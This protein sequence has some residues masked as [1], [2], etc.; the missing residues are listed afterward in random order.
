MGVGLP[1]I[2]LIGEDL[3][4]AEWV[5]IT[6]KEFGLGAYRSQTLRIITKMPNPALAHAWYYALLR[7][8][9][10]YVD[11][12]NA[13]TKN[14]YICVAN[15]QVQAKPEAQAW[16]IQLEHQGGSQYSIKSTFL[17]AGGMHFRPS[18]MA[19]LR[20][21]D[22]KYVRSLLLSGEPESMM[23]PLEPRTFSGVL[24]FAGITDGDYRLTATLRYGSEDVVSVAI[25]LSVSRQPD[26]W[27]VEIVRTQDFEQ[28]TGVKW[29]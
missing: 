10:T 22:D 16:P 8:R 18:C 21:P 12:Q 23:L 4:C 15:K 25:P 3:N 28:R 19:V 17:N 5:E 24:D 27:V 26:R 29:R 7:L 14:A 13:G 20:S 1:D 6:P 2:G 11:G 9:A